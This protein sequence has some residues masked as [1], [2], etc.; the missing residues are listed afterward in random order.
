MSALA[1]LA[2]EL[3]VIGAYH[4]FD[5]A[6]RVTRPETQAALLAAMGVPATEADAAERLA[7]IKAGR[8]DRLAPAEMILPA[9]AAAHIS[10]TTEADWALTLEGED[11]PAA[12]GRGRVVET[13]ALPAGVHRL[14][15]AAGSRAG[16]TWLLAAPE[17]APSLQELT[18]EARLWGVTAPLYGLTSG[19][20]AGLGNYEDLGALAASIGGRGGAF[21]GVNPVHA[22]GVV[23][24]DGLISPYS[25]SHR[26]FLDTRHIAVGGG[27]GGGEF[28]DYAAAAGHI[29]PALDARYAE[30]EAASPDHPDRAA[31]DAFAE[32]GGGALRQFALHEALSLSH[33][34]DWRFWPAM[35]RAPA[36]AERFAAANG[37][38]IRRH[39]FRQWLADRQLGAA[40]ARA[41]AAGMPIGLH[42]DLA[43]GPRPG[44]AE[45]WGSAA[46]AHGVSLGAPPDAFAPGGQTWGLAP[47]APAGLAAAGYLPF[48]AL[49]SATMRRAGMIR[50]DHVLGFARAFWAPEDGTPGGYVRYPMAALIAV[51]KIVAARQRTLVVGEDLGLVES[52]LRDALA[53]AGIYGT[54]LMQFDWDGMTRERAL[55]SFGTHDTPTLRGYFSGADIELREAHGQIGAEESA[56]ARRERAAR[57]ASFGEPLRDAVHRRLANGPA[58]LVAAQLDDLAGARQQQNLPGTVDKHPNWRRRIAPDVEAWA[59]EPALIETAAIMAEAGRGGRGGNT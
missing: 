4:G 59:D 24:P 7:A 40:Q 43:V 14:D 42:L 2:A 35:L 13:P 47:F 12:A 58:A 10:L 57:R 1:R 16:K 54:D 30:L 50:I 31:L 5:G 3:G 34:P 29:G 32:A 11:L 17:T 45:T 44:G 41:K 53:G 18:G 49:L 52:G 9:G 28:A 21:L 46:H 20:N 37:R 38:E 51:T 48:A 6:E 55:A 26:E 33:G 56:A 27:G 15:V 23:A 19:R 25:P 39:I 36:G 8:Q 22:L